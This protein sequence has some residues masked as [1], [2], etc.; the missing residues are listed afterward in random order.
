MTPEL[1]MRIAIGATYLVI[2]VELLF[3]PIPSEASTYAVL[4]NGA[5][6]DCGKRCA[7]MLGYAALV[8]VFVL[9]AIWALY[10]HSFRPL[11]PFPAEPAFGRTAV[12]AF[13]IALLALG[14]TIGVV[15]TAQLRRH[16][17]RGQGLKRNGIFAHSRNPIVLSLHLT[18]LGL[19]LALPVLPLLAALPVYL[20]HM[21][22][23]IRM[24]EAHLAERFDLEFLHYSRQVRRYWGRRRAGQAGPLSKG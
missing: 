7:S 12:A 2:A 24:E 8:V 20:V 4:T 14:T 5:R 18:A 17:Q 19:V 3:F 10:P 16:R 23:R 6:R 13:S 11:T 22:G 1:W 21:H 9:P 15:A